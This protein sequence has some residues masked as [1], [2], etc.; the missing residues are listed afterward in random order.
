MAAQAAS[1][2]LKPM[3]TI[4]AEQAGINLYSEYSLH[5]QLK[6]YLAGPGDRIEVPVEGKV[7][8]LVRADGELVEVQTGH[9]GQ[10]APKALGLVEKGYRIRIVYPVS[11]ERMLRRLDPGTGE[12][13]SVRRSPKRGDLYSL[14]D[15]LVHASSFVAAK[16]ITVE[17]LLVRSVETRT[18]DGT[19]S[20][21]KKGDRTVD[22]ALE[23]VI[24]SKSFCSSTQWMA[25]IPR[26]LAPPWDSAS[27][28]A[29][30]GIGPER[31]RRILY[32]FCR[33]GLLVEL[34]GAGRR[35][36][37]GR[38]PARGRKVETGS[39]DTSA[40]PS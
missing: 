4:V 36:T 40:Q 35:K 16:N 30:L 6:M 24:A 22:R 17:V 9:I 18:R 13:I 10:L 26:E 1:C 3:G 15:E 39:G 34:G 23:E 37:Y 11:A 2:I 32:C 14:F 31:A 19:G 25:I 5:E 8:D 27:L 28:G 20:W 7:V 33:A 12:V 29:A 38:A 21:W